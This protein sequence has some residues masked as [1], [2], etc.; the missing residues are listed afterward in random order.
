[1]GGLIPPISDTAYPEPIS[2]PIMS[3]HLLFS[4]PCERRTSSPYRSEENEV[5]KGEVIC[6]RAPSWGSNPHLSDRKACA[7][8]LFSMCSTRPSLAAFTRREG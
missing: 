2:G 3:F 6:A 5:Q 4:K 1:M 8:L 7:L